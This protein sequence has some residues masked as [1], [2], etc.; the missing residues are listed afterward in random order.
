MITESI[1]WKQDISKAAKQLSVILIKSN[2]CD[3]SI[4]SIEKNV[5]FIAYGIRKLF[6]SKKLTLNCNKVT[7]T[8]ISYKLLKKIHRLNAWALDRIIDFNSAKHEQKNILFLCNQIIH[9][10]VFSVVGEGIFL[11]SDFERN[12]KIL[13]F[14]IIEFI[15]IAKRLANNN[16]TRLEMRYNYKTNEF[17]VTTC[18]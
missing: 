10:Y 9:S 12:K 4:Y 14:E 17:D 3:K 5:N 11:C 13:F 16:V 7:T 18:E 8:I 15:K 1:F 6:E 2:Y